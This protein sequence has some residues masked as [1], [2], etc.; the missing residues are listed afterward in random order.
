MDEDED[1]E[2]EEFVGGEKEEREGEFGREKLTC[3]ENWVSTDAFPSPS[4]SQFI[5]V[6]DSHLSNDDCPLSDVLSLGDRLVDRA[7]RLF[8]EL[9]L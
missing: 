9:V 1:E 5:E 8:F 6:T 4:E 2:E 3:A 7:C